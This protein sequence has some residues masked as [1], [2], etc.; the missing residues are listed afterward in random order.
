MT[1]ST[2]HSKVTTL[3]PP[4]QP[5]VIPTSCTTPSFPLQKHPPHYLPLPITHVMRL[6]FYYL[7]FSGPLRNICPK[8]ARLVGVMSRSEGERL[9]FARA[10]ALSANISHQGRHRESRYEVAPGI[11]STLNRVIAARQ[12][13]LFHI[14][15][16]SQ[17]LGNDA[18]TSPSD[19]ISSSSPPL[20]SNT[21]SLSTP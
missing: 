12:P 2:L 15:T 20:S 6:L 5:I 10:T 11:T 13:Y 21:S 9:L 18:D 3:H 7:S 16:G 1:V 17:D 4:T 14:R 8:Y 19:A